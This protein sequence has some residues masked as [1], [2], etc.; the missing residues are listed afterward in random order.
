MELNIQNFG[1]INIKYLVFDYN[2]TLAVDGNLIKDID[3]YLVKFSKE[4]EIYVITSDTN[5]SAAKNLKNLPVKLK[6]L[7]SNNHTKE[8]EDFIKSLDSSKVI[9]IGNGNN[10]SFMLKEAKIGVCVIQEEGAS[11]KALI[12]SDIVLKNIY[13]FFDLL[14]NPKRLI[15]TLRM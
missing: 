15:A 7:D 9:A 3:K 14:S 13:D 11:A 4:F 5:G 2:G 1:K 10:D 8:K 6:V 12:N